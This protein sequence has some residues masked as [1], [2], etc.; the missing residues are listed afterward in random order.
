MQ[1]IIELRVDPR[2]AATEMMLRA[3]VSTHMGIDA[4]RIN[5][6]RVIPANDG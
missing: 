6:L 3:A 2:T 4:N 5:H 1:D